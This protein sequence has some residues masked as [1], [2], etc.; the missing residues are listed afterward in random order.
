MSKLKQIL[1]A[2]VPTIA[3][4]LGGPLAGAAVSMVT[5]KLGLT[6][7]ATATAE[8]KEN[9]VVEALQNGG[10]EAWAKLKEAEH[11]FKIKMKEL[12][13]DVEQIHQADRASARQRQIALKDKA[14]VILASVIMGMF[15]TVLILQFMIVFQQLIIEPASLRGL[16]ISFGILG[17]A[18]IAVV[19][20]YFGSSSSSARKTELMGAKE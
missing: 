5:E 7:E 15:T 10:P 6:P 9:A 14:P 18:V 13:I 12:N 19:Q 3:T 2:V 1:G 8:Q 17:G 16:D 11:D 20:Y 4:A